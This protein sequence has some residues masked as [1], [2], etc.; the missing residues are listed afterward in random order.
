MDAKERLEQHLVMYERENRYHEQRAAQ[1]RLTIHSIKLKLR[2]IDLW[3]KAGKSW[4][5]ATEAERITI[6][7][8]AMMELKNS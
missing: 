4:R 6:R 1:T 5:D 3:R 8:I 2:M 7:R